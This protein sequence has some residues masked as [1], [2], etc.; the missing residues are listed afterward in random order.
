LNTNV[1]VNNSGLVLDLFTS[2][3]LWFWTKPENHIN[4]PFKN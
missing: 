3:I 4:V 1:P 2:S